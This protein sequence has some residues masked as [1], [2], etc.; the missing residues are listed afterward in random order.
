MKKNTNI[1]FSLCFLICALAVFLSNALCVNAEQGKIYT[2]GDSKI[3]NTKI[4]VQS[5]KGENVIVLPSTAS[6]ES[7]MLFSGYSGS[8]DINIKGDKKTAEFSDGMVIDLA[9]FCS[10]NDY[11]LKF[12]FSNETDSFESEITFLFSENI[13]AIYLLSDDPIEKGREWVEMSADKSNKATGNAVMQKSDGEVVYDGALTQIKGRGN[14]TWSFVKKP[15]QIKTE[16]KVDLLQTENPDNT[17]KTWVLLANYMDPSLLRN[18]FALDIGKI[19]SMPVNIENTHVDLYY[20][21]EYRGNYLLAE[22]AEVGSGRVDVTD[23]EKKNESANEGTDLEK[24]PIST[25]TTANGAMYTYCE[26]MQSPED[27]SGGYLLEMDYKERALA[28]VCYFCT[29]RNQYVVV[30]SPEYASKAEMEYIATLYQEYEDAIYNK[31][32]NP[33]TN[34]KYSDYVDARSVACYYLVNEFSKARDCFASSAYL[35]KNAGEDKMYMG[36][37]WDYDLSFGTSNYEEDGYEDASGMSP[38]NTVMGEKLLG[39]DEFSQLVKEIYLNELYPKIKTGDIGR[40]DEYDFIK[41]SADVNAKMWYGNADMEEQ[42]QALCLFVSQRADSLSEIYNSY[43]KENPYWDVLKSAWYYDEISQA[44]KYGYMS[45]MDNGFF[46]PE[47]CLRRS[48]IA[49]VIYNM[50]QTP[51]T[52]FK[53]LFDDVK[54]DSWFGDAVMWN[55]DSGIINGY[56]D[57]QFKPERYVS[58]EELLLYLY[59]YFK[60]PSVTTDKIKEFDD[61]GMVS[62]DAVDAVEWA[63]NAGI[64]EGDANMLN[65]K[66]NLTRA[67]LA[68]ILVRVNNIQ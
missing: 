13:P 16:I 55:T 15:Y 63:I 52:E 62:A 56:P 64:I 61:Y 20:D 9:E 27:I 60:T 11:K 12:T 29:T 59:R 58:R 4:N 43:S 14:S 48:E 32:I 6:T 3:P 28:E 17:S 25:A 54:E 57:G 34:K 5:M 39:I 35:H 23:L 36:P 8:Y 22:K 31:G 26:G 68:T 50:A 66:D 10:G 41:A 19:L 1:K 49:Q 24:L 38:Y 44:T 46:E 33:I 30:K 67:E 37:L 51:S 21:G 18:S 47:T 40:I 65:P 53:P 42:R 2:Y 45:G 7:V